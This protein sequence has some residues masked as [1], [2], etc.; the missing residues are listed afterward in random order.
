MLVNGKEKTP[1]QKKNKIFK[2]K[3]DGG[4]III[5]IEIN[6]IKTKISKGKYF[7]FN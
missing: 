1:Q 6:T 5:K 4:T 7:N 2:I 3:I